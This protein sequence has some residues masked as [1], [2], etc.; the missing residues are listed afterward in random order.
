MCIEDITHKFLLMY[1][2]Y[3]RHLAKMPRC[4]EILAVAR[5][6]LLSG[7]L[8]WPLRAPSPGVFRDRFKLPS[9]S[10]VTKGGFLSVNIYGITVG[11]KKLE[12]GCRMVYAGFPSFLHLGSEDRHTNFLPSTVYGLYYSCRVDVA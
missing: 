9:F 12:S 1:C 2:Q 4:S 8:T 7:I 5:L 10:A 6:R 3:T 11:S